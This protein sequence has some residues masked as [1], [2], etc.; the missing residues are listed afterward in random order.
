[1]Q[2]RICLQLMCL[3]FAFKNYVIIEK[4]K[5]NLAQGVD[6]Q[7]YGMFGTYM[8]IHLYMHIN[9]LSTIDVYVPADSCAP[10]FL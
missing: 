5:H 3:T 10:A 9:T 1:M 2:N 8:Y 4:I 6:V 7:T